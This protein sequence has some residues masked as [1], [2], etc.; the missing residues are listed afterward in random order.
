MDL[1]LLGMLSA[2]ESGSSSSKKASGN[3]VQ[4]DGLQGGVPFNSVTVSGKNLL[5]PKST[6][7]HSNGV[8]AVLNDKME[9]AS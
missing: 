4:L 1:S 9:K 2:A 7:Y 8:D 5:N 3:P 6:N